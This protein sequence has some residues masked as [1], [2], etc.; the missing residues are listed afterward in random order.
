M[1]PAYMEILDTTKELRKELEDEIAENK[2]KDKKL[3]SLSRE[4][5]V[6]YWTLSHQD[7]T[8]LAHE[9]EIAS[10]KS[11]IKSLKQHLHKALQDLRY[12]GDTSTA[13]D[14]HILRLEDKVD[15][16]KNRI[17]KITDKKLSQ[18]N[19]STMALPDIL[20]NV[21]TA[22]DRVERYIDG[23]TSF[24]PKIT[25]N[26]IR[27][28]L[29]TVRGHMERHVQDAINLQGQLNTA[30]NLLNN[31]NRQINNFFNDMANVR[32]ECLRRAQLLTIAYN[33]EAN[34]RRRWWQIAQER[35][36]ISRR[37]AF[38]KQNRINI[39]TQKKAVLQILVRRCKAEA[40]L[41]EFN[42]AWVFNRYQKWKAREL[43]S[44]QIILNLQNNP[45]GNM[46]TIQDVMTSMAPLLAQIPQYEGQEPPDTYH[47]KVMQAISYGHNLGVAGF[48]DAM[49]VTVLSG[50]MGGRFVPPNPFNNGAGN[51]VNTPALF[52]AWLR[53]KY[54]E[55]KI[56]AG[57][58]SMAT[59]A[60]Q[61]LAPSSQALAI[62]PQKDDFKIRL[63]RD[64][65]YSGIATDDTT[66]ENFIYEELQ[67]RLGSKTAHVRKSPFTPRSAYATK[68][69]V[70]KVVPK[71]S[72]KQTRHCSACGKTG[73]TKVNCPKG[74]RTKKVNHVYQEVV[75][76]PENSEEEYIEEY[77]GED[78]SK[79]EEIEDDEEEEYDD[80]NESASGRNCYA[81]K[82]KWCEVEYL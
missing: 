3:K 13:Q 66:L 28:S 56:E 14:I 76:D 44:R 78:D 29:T 6:C 21:A 74:K 11:E 62:Q 12:K 35:Q 19:S 36:T 68:K 60:I 23:D 42:R 73:H 32:N 54:H 72:A 31:A 79:E 65:A 18:I 49:K 24:D 2:L 52:Q 27:I 17:R 57:G 9:D 5:E 50:K 26:G 39:L 30:H 63:A 40:D 37:M 10:F 80:D 38:R 61:Q 53:D 45:P 33:N 8:I 64:L 22:L 48:N 47:N 51:A 1:D 55:V 20:R 70:R 7:S 77:I 4:L 82:K 43:N 59:Q 81:V 69:V 34:E 75:E 41:A 71:A 16:L 67:K 46:A 58:P 25:L 15:Q